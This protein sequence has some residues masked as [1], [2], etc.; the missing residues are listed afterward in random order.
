[1]AGDQHSV[2]VGGAEPSAEDNAAALAAAAESAPATLEEAQAKIAAESAPPAQ[3]PEGL[4]EKFKS[5]DDMAKAYSE[6]E[7]KLGGGSEEVAQAGDDDIDEESLKPED[8]EVADQEGNVVDITKY[9]AEFAESG[10]LSE[11]SYAELAAR[12]FDKATV[13]GYIAGQQALAELA[14][15]R[16]TEAAGGKDSMDRMFAWATTALSGAEIDAFNESFQN[17]DVNAAVLTMGQLKAKY[18]AA[19]GRDPKLLGGKPA[20]QDASVF[21]SWAEVQ[22]AMNDERYAK[23]HAYRTR[24][25]QKLSR[26]N[27]IR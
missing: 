9:D 3:R 11:D 24:I 19:N 16:I 18:E 14:T 2:T 5:W 21:T 22:A 26:S 20:G 23:D 6:L 7:K 27:N 1:M 8:H 13:D 17:A 15:M 25:E 12:G 4:P 10:E